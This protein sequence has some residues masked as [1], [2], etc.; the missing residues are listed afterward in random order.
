MPKFMSWYLE[1]CFPLLCETEPE[2]LAHHYT[3]AAVPA[4]AMPYWQ[5]AGQRAIERSANVEAISHLS[6]ALEVLGLLPDT[7]E[8]TR[9][10]L[11]L[12][13]ALG[14]SLLT[15]RGFSAPEVEHVYTRARELCQRLEDIYEIGPVL[16]GLWGF[17]EVRGDLRTARELA[18][19]LLTLA[20]HQHDS[21]LLLQGHRAL[22]DTLYWLGEFVSARAHQEQ[23]IALYNPQQHR[24]HALLYGQDPGMGC[25][26]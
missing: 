4:Q 15:T 6:K 24:P 1:V 3:E 9:Q 16:F 12:Q 19:Q 23:G 11:T 26:V 8:R 10:E 25:R 13:R 17:Y 7:S 22:G 20:Q 21:T 5:Q 2:L 14:A 18:E